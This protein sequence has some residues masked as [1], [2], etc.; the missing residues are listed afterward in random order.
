MYKILLMLLTPYLIFFNQSYSIADPLM[1]SII[2]SAHGAKVQGER[3]KVI[4]ENLANKDSTGMSPNENP[5]RRKTIIFKNKM[6][7]KLGLK[8]VQIHKKDYDHSEF[9][10]K[11]SPTHPAADQNGYVKLPNVN[12]LIEKADQM[13][14]QRSYEANI[15]VIENSKALIA[16]S[17]DMLK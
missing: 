8:I 6:D 1:Q 14:A 17:L 2:V 7:R 9:H 12:E 10:K 5:Y 4:S 3:I 15:N 13:E 11:Y 16:K